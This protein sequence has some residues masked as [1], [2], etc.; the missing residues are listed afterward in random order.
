[1][2]VWQM[3]KVDQK[4]TICQHSFG[5]RKMSP[6]ALQVHL[7]QIRVQFLTWVTPP[8]SRIH[9][10]VHIFVRF[11]KFWK[12]KYSWLQGH[13]TSR[14]FNGRQIFNLGWQKWWQLH[15][16]FLIM[17]QLTQKP[18]FGRT[19]HKFYWNLACSIWRMSLIM[20][21][22]AIWSRSRPD[23]TVRAFVRVWLRS[24]RCPSNFGSY[25][26][27]LKLSRGQAAMKEINA[28][29][30]DPANK[31]RTRQ[32]FEIERMVEHHNG[33]SEISDIKY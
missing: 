19:K 29:F 12:F 2:T 20:S 32:L 10:E 7:K 3:A 31:L 14:W 6:F 21:G 16:R 33:L 30:N 25:W 8:T 1:M 27:N 28:E 23:R 11:W 18:S 13:V 5:F 17:V 4:W 22:F 15:I 9:S 24:W 26:V